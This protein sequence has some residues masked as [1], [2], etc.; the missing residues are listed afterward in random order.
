MRKCGT[1]YHFKNKFAVGKDE[2][3]CSELGTESEDNA[4]GDYREGRHATEQTPEVVLN[5]AREALNEEGAMNFN[6][7]QKENLFNIFTDIFTIE[8]DTDIVL[9]KIK[10]EIEKQGYYLP[11]NANKILNYSSK[12]TDLYLLYRMTLATGMAAYLEDIMKFQIEKL[13]SDP[14]KYH[15][16]PKDRPFA[17]EPKE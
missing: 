15:P 6:V 5:E 7:S 17:R 12:L 4:C 11:F 8:Q 10:D 13:F 1:C 14:R 16:K 2:F 3:S 9:T